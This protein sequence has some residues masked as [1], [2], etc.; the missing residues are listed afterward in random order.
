[1][2][3]G[4]EAFANSNTVVTAYLEKSASESLGDPTLPEVP[5]LTLEEEAKLWSKLDLRLL[6]ILSLMYL[7]SY[8]DR[9]V[10]VLPSF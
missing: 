8:M 10:V 4:K 6:P 5:Q 9:C 3:N 1:M 7:M 2:S